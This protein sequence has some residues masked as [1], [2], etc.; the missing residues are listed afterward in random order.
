MIVE[1]IRS[2]W[3][4]VKLPLDAVLLLY[5][6]LNYRTVKYISS[7]ITTKSESEL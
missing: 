6:L 3:I 5:Y 2:I 7:L 1:I 4:T